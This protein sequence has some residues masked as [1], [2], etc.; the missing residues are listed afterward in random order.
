MVLFSY[1]PHHPHPHIFQTANMFF[2][3]IQND[4]ETQIYTGS[5]LG[6]DGPW[7]LFECP[8]Q[9]IYTKI[10]RWCNVM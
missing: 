8:Y 3:I 10:F 9:K 5:Y 6:E 7:L 2:I 1:I 4:L